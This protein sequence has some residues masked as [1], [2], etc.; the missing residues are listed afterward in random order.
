M[1]DKPRRTKTARPV[2]TRR[3]IRQ[4]PGIA[5]KPES[6]SKRLRS[7]SSAAKSVATVP[8]ALPS[9]AR[10]RRADREPEAACGLLRRAS[11][12][13]LSSGTERWRLPPRNLRRP[14]APALEIAAALSDELADFARRLLEDSTARARELTAARTLPELLEIQARQLTAVSDA[15]LQHTARMR[16]IF[17]ARFGE[18]S[19]RQ[20]PQRK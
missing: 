13:Q 11:D 14:P 1:A 17:L 4:K 12:E 9:R 8:V 15:W 3:G 5:E 7:R 16:E 6:A 18:K 2:R 19:R 10:G 20:K